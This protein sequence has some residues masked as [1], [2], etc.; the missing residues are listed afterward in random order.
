MAADLYEGMRRS[1]LSMFLS[2]QIW[3]DLANGLIGNKQQTNKE[4]QKHND[5][6]TSPSSTTSESPGA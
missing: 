3:R 4:Q 5:P 2:I 6:V 1:P